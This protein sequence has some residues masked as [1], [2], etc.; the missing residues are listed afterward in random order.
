MWHLLDQRYHIPVVKMEVSEVSFANLEKYNVLLMPN[1]SYG[2]IGKRGKENIKRWLQAGGTIVAVKNAVRW[3]SGSKLTQLEYTNS[4]ATDSTHTFS[5]ARLSA[6]R[7]SQRIGG[8]IFEATLD[9]T[10]PL[11][12][13]FTSEKIPVFRNSDIF[14]KKSKNVYANPLVYTDSPL[15]SG[16]ISQRNLEK[17][18]GTAAITV[19]GVGRGRVISMV[20]NPNFRAF[21]YGTN[22]LFANAIFFGDLIS[23]AATD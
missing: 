20:D 7:G 22:K 1:G 18:K 12:Y 17:L 16:Y 6:N 21:W 9:I 10:H 3:L 14:I 5:Y 8:A 4:S 2:S 19:S 13:G 11:G 15:L 23:G